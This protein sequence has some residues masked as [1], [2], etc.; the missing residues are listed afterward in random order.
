MPFIFNLR[1]VSTARRH[2]HSSQS[3]PDVVGCGQ[4]E[5]AERAQK[6]TSVLET[7]TKDE[8]PMKLVEDPKIPHGQKKSLMTTPLPQASRCHCQ[9]GDE[10]VETFLENKTPPPPSKHC[11]TKLG[12]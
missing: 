11:P 10:A 8:P 6:A 9:D 7:K 12:S 2:C 3:R 1:T 5:V 4:P